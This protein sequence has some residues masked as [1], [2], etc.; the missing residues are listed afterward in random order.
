[1]KKLLAATLMATAACTAF[2]QAPLVTCASINAI[3]VPGAEKQDKICL[4][5]LSTKYLVAVNRTDIS[6]WGTLHSQATRNP[7]GA[8]PGIQ[9]DGYFPDTSTTNGY[10]GWFHDAQP[11]VL[12]QE[13]AG[14]TQ[15]FGVGHGSARYGIRLGNSCDYRHAPSRAMPSRRRRLFAYRQVPRGCVAVRIGH[16]LFEASC[17]PC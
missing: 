6:D 10:F 16:P 8:V 14:K 5:D 12:E 1:M 13:G 11:A 7:P 2:A 3:N 17:R 4:A 15:E 9:I